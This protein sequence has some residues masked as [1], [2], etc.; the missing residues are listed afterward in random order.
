RPAPQPETAPR[1]AGATAAR[2]PGR[3]SAAANSAR[4][5]GCSMA[6]TAEDVARFERLRGR[7]EAIA[8]R[9][10][11]SASEAEDAVQETFLR[12]QAAHLERIEGPQDLLTEVLNTICR[13]R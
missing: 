8:Y 10:L 12:W 4:Q 2:T 1:A 5:L 7:L 9:M 13:N 11:G 6:M 3:S